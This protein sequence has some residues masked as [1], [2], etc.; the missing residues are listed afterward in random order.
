MHQP[1][2]YKSIL[3]ALRDGVYV[4]DRNRLITYWNP[5]A[6][7][8][9]GYASGE[10]VGRFCFDDI[11]QHVDAGGNNLCRNGC[12]LAAT[13]VDGQPREVEVYLRHRDG[14]RVAVKVRAMPLRDAS[15]RVTGAVEVF[16]ENETELAIRRQQADLERA[17][18][19]DPLTLV[20]NRRFA[21]ATLAVNLG[22]VKRLGW[23][24]GIILADVDLF[25]EVNDTYGHVTG[26]RALRTIAATMAGAVRIYDLVARW[27]G[28]EFMVI[29]PGIDAADLAR[30]ANRL[31]MLVS[32]SELRLDDGQSLSLS[33][34]IGAT[35]ATTDDTIESLIARADAALYRSKAEGRNRVTMG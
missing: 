12:P 23:R 28:E 13:I 22:E 20:A 31:R 29:C 24:L 4:V 7:G 2:R 1:D 6:A 27:G 34:S 30:L 9:S 19:S 33:I 17:A 8:L 15:G 35:I 18:L 14:R 25:K 5:A 10:V 3:D 21:E 16:S 26:D 11:L 32:R